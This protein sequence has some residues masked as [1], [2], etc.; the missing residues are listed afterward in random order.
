MKKTIYTTAILC[1]LVISQNTVFAQG[2]D[3]DNDDALIAS[4]FNTLSDC[5][6]VIS[7]LVNNYNFTEEEACAW[8]GAG[9]SPDGFQGAGTLGNVCECSCQT[10]PLS[11]DEGY[12]LLTLNYFDAAQNSFTVTNSIGEEMATYSDLN[13][14]GSI[15]DCFLTS[16]Q[17]DCFSI[18][19]DGG[20][21]FSWYLSVD[22]VVL[23]QGGASDFEFGPACDEDCNDDDA[24]VEQYFG[25]FFVTECSALIDYLVV[26][27]NYT[28]SQA[29]NWDGTP[30]AN[31]GGLI[32]SDFC[33]CSCQENVFIE[34]HNRVLPE[35]IMIKDLMG[36]DVDQMIKNTPLLLIYKD[37]SIKK[38]MI[39]T[40]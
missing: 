37:G 18:D 15:Q 19:I 8:D 10:A 14:D 33:E 22:D 24:L 7:Y 31:F 28:Q 23:L 20:Q 12:T 30:M 4:V 25:N 11:C 9:F 35:L 6:Q 36:R 16:A 21:N 29:C 5:D 38:T 34:N 39:K 26:N 17:N 2:V 27:Y 40:N 32:I 13:G 3:C 1:L